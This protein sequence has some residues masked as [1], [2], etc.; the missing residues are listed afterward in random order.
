M[1]KIRSFVENLAMKSDRFE[2][3]DLVLRHVSE[4]VGGQSCK[5]FFVEKGYLDKSHLP[6][7]FEVQIVAVDGKR[8][9]ML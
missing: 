2:V 3:Y 9:E 5:I 6:K 1:D 4:L 8:M 7:H